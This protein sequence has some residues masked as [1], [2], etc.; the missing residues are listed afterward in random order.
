MDAA[1]ETLM[2]SERV[3]KEKEELFAAPARV[4]TQ[5][6][7]LL[8]EVY[9]DTKG[10]PPVIRRAKLFDRICAEKEILIDMNPIVGTITGY[11]YGSYPQPEMGARWMKKVDKLGLQRGNALLTEEERECI[12][13]A[14]DYWKDTNLFNRARDVVLKSLGI[15]FSVWQK[16]GVGTEFAPYGPMSSSP[17]FGKVI[18]DGFTGI[19]AE[20]EAEKGKLAIGNAEDIEKWYFYEGTSMCLNA[21]INLAG[22]YASQARKMAGK[23][24]NTQ[25]K[26]ELERIAEVCEWVPANPARSFH[27]AIQATWFTIL[28]VWIESPTTLFAPPSR[29]P[30]YT[31]SLYCSDKATNMITDEDVIELLEFFFLKLNGLA[32]VIA[33]HGFAWSQSRL[34]LHLAVG[35]LTPNGEDAT[36]ELDWLVLEAQRRIQLPE[37]LVDLV[38]H[39]KLSDDF[40]LKCVELV[41]TGIGQPAFHNAD[42]AIARHLYHDKMP[43]EEA[44]NVSIVGCVQSC[45]PGYSSAPWE[46]VF[47]TAKMIELALNNGKDPLTGTPLGPQTGQAESFQSYEEFY[48]A[49]V[50]QMEYFIPLARTMCR[51]S[52]NLKK[53]LP[54]PFASV[55]TN[56][57]IKNGK[58]LQDG[59]ARYHAANAMSFVAGVDSANSLAAIKKLVFDEKQFGMK[60]LKDALAADFE[61]YEEIQKMCLD[62]PKYGNDDKYVD[63]IVKELYQICYREHQ[64]FADYFERPTKPEAFSVTSHFAMGRFTGALPNGRKARTPLTDASVSATP[65]TDKSGPTALIK[66]AAKVIDTVKFGGNHFNMKFHPSALDGVDKARKFL[67]LI[68]TYMDLGGYH[69]QFNCVDSEDLRDAQL[70]PEKYRNLVV[71]VAGFS[72]FFI[73]LDPEVQGEII[74]RTELTL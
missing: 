72:A 14:V 62:A 5:R 70:H 54:V 10:E 60:K 69:V 58:D 8:L 31:Y 50:K 28:G 18:N 20:I 16:C 63:Q 66:S 12:Y 48:G 2:L 32:M 1:V 11:K 34:G 67:S 6:A 37:P 39:D 36:N 38:Y 56:D 59:G 57:C 42:I 21:M 44:R 55:V 71:R 61:G 3:R 19:L 43:L 29:L 65:G 23:E 47:N 68:K 41:R 40:L 52:W 30:Q 35:G 49:V 25:R 45:V 15:D 26:R 51:T 9:E 4:D 17:D 33:P 46:A 22:R 27:E 24:S 13:N 73:Y 64:K 74:K 7:Q 53:D